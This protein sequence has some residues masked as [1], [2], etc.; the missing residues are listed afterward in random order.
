MK[1]FTNDLKLNL[2][3]LYS[4]REKIL[5]IDQEIGIKL[6]CIQSAQEMFKLHA[7]NQSKI[8]I[9]LIHDTLKKTACKNST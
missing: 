1:R 9:L 6:F 7:K 2:Q 5:K 8:N 3:T 4:I